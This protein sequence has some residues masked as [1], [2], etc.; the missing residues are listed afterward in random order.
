MAEKAGTEVR[1]PVV[2]GA[3]LVVDVRGA[4]VEAFLNHLV[5]VSKS[6]L[7]KSGPTTVGRQPNIVNVVPGAA[8]RVG[9]AEAQD[10][11]RLGIRDHASNSTRARAA[12]RALL[13]M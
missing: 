6:V 1:P 7:E 2:A 12:I 13:P 9:V 3:V 4:P 11:Q 5:A 10:T 8:V